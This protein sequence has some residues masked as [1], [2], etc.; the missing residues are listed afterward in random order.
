LNVSVSVPGSSANLG[1]G[2]DA[3][4]LALELRLRVSV[5]PAEEKG[6]STLDVKG[7]GADRLRLNDSNR[8]LAGLRAGARAA[9]R[10]DIDPLRIEMDNAIPLS[11]GLGSSAA[12]TVAG[13]LV[14]REL[15]GAPSSADELIDLAT[16]V[17]GHPE[18]AAA[19]LLGGFVVCAA[20]RATRLEPPPDLRAVV[21]IPERKI[22]TAD[23]RAVLPATIPH[24]DAA[25]NAAATAAVVAAFATG[26]LSLLEAMYE[27]R[28]HQPYRAKAYP[29]LPAML[30]AARAAGALGAAL[31][32]AGS[33]V[34]GLCGDDGTAEAVRQAFESAARAAHLIGTAQGVGIA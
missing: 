33:S 8:F 29:E 34:I 24:Q 15:Y 20:G 6:K 10:H 25:H 17:E 1:P 7:E 9:G 5:S 2:Y 26:D 4:A 21:F 27:D 19:S 32:G 14:A 23:M 3:L 18:N 31:S 22:A 13:L 30:E 16:S 12:A 28:L 11:R